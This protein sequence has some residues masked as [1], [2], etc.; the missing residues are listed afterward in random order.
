VTTRSE[1]EALTRDGLIERARRLGV[2]RPEVM[3]R[4]EMI[5]EIIRRQETDAIARRRA[6]G[7]LGV[8]R[9]LVASLIEQG[10]NLPDTAEL[11]RKGALSPTH[12][13]HQ[14]PVATVTL[15]EIYAAQGH[16]KRAAGMLE[17]VLEKEP[18]HAPARAL[19][20]RLRRD[21]TRPAVREAEPEEADA[22]PKPEETAAHAAPEAPSLP[23]AMAAPPAAPATQADAAPSEPEAPLAPSAPL[24]S[25]APAPSAPEAAAEPPTLPA[26]AMPPEAVAPATAP[27]VVG[28]AP[29]P[30]ALAAPPEP[31]PMP[32]PPAS[33]PA[34]SPPEPSAA[35][36]RREPVRAD[37]LV[38]VLGDS[39][40]FVKWELSE[41]SQ[42]ER[43]GAEWVVRVV[44]HVP[45]MG[46]ALRIEMDLPVAEDVGYRRLP[47]R[48][49]AS[50][51]A[52]LG[53]R[54]VHGIRPL[55]V[56]SIVLKRDG[57]HELAFT[58]F[59]SR[60]LPPALVRD[61]VAAS[62]APLLG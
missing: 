62:E 15:A 43:I 47:L 54:D 49:G 37:A 4:V 28:A 29:E 55:V 50:V 35:P 40:C 6:R 20:E 39:D 19:L 17:E 41:K 12:L 24:A 38:I 52:V 9:D 44:S 57:A 58:P 18:D 10:L 23:E 34:P 56:A 45:R 53:T 2:P 7:W 36:S 8:A 13:Q 51:R 3:T 32:A 26:L 14:P 30:E 16:V 46:R 61:V 60:A 48:E 25:P 21:R 33:E 59:G 31:M 5:D 27:E 11:V 1:L 42:R 22:S